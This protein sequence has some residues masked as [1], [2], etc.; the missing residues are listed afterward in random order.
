MA[1][2][3]PDQF[4]GHRNLGRGKPDR[5]PVAP[6][7]G[8]AQAQRPR[9][10]GPGRCVG[11]AWRVPPLGLRAC[12]TCSRSEFQCIA[13]GGGRPPVTEVVSS[14]CLT[15]LPTCHQWFH[16]DTS[17][18]PGAGRP[19]SGVGDQTLDHAV[20]R[21][22]PSGFD[23]LTA[24]ILAW[25]WSTLD[26]AGRRDEE[27]HLAGVAAGRGQCAGHRGG[28]N[29]LGFF[30][31]KDSVESQNQALLK[32]DTTQAAGYVSSLASTLSS[33]LDASAP[34]VASTNGSP[35]AF[36]TQARPLAA[37]PFTL[38]LARKVGTQFDAASV[39]G[40]G[41][42]AGQVLD[43]ELSAAL[44]K[45][46]STVAPGPVRY[47]GKTSTF[48]LSLGPPLV[49]KGFALYEQ[50][51]LDPF[52]AITATQAAPFHVLNASVYATRA[53]ATSQLVLANT[54]CPAP[55]GIDGRSVCPG[56]LGFVVAAR[57]RQEPPGG[58]F[59]QCG[60]VRRARIRR[61][62]RARSGER[63]RGRGATAALCQCPRGPTHR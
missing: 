5:A 27:R 18:I 35:A 15:C 52:V 44:D 41:F 28:G 60:T 55:G 47:N 10:E 1:R 59:P 63:D 51:S 9:P 21:R 58:P 4:W 2:E 30:L 22:R 40:S 26:P 46:G 11:E 7:N 49:P 19:S 8:G 57:H 3:D 38:L 14:C 42:K 33:T 16:L 23:P 25:A 29:F 50:V 48:G 20:T 31:A 43:P 6:G 61:A 36:E 39:V 32:D 53:P 17:V 12:E 45:A 13:C 24:T 62:S 37:G 56:G 54:L 34:G